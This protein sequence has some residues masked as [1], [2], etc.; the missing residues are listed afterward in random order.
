MKP[1]HPK[2]IKLVL[3]LF[4]TLTASSLQAA[5]NAVTT[6]MVGHWQGNARIIVNWCKQ[7]HLQVEIDI[8]PDGSVTGTVGDATLTKGQFTR[9]R[10]WVGRKLNLATDYIV[11]GD[12]KGPVVAA[13]GITRSSVSM[14]ID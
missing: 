1:T 8:H 13:E 5:D 9:N 4:A 12:L 3:L 10:G 14:P 11:R 7:P 6:S 2:I